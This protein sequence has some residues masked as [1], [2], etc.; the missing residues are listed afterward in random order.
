M[1]FR[2]NGPRV[3]FPPDRDVT[4]TVF[5]IQRYSVHDGAGIRTIVFLKGCPLRCRWCSNPESQASRPELARNETRCIGTE[6]CDYCLPAC[7]HG[8]LAIPGS[9][10]PEV[11]REKC[12]G[13]MNCA[14]LCPAQAFQAYGTTRTVGGI[15]DAVERDSPFFSRSEGGMTLSG[16]EPLMQADFALALLRE[17]RRRHIDCALETCG[18]VPWDVLNQACGLLRE[19]FFDI[20]TMDPE[21]HRRHTGADNALILD[22]LRRILDGFPEIR[23]CV[24]TPVVPSFNDTPQDVGL[25]LDFL[26]SYPQVRY[27]LLPYHRLGVQKYRHLDRPFPLGEAVLDNRRMAALQELAAQRRPRS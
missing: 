2:R 17:S 8:A 27:E 25:I 15:L 10:V 6:R 3:A 1:T 16:G 24:R 20:K 14:A 22:N 21:K 23:L 12:V 9:G 5:N 7:S 19:I 18:Q 11:D 26:E 13:C 4:G